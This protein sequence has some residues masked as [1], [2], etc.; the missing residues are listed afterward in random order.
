MYQEELYSNVHTLALFYLSNSAYFHLSPE[1]VFSTYILK[2][3]RQDSRCCALHLLTVSFY[4]S[5]W[6]M[7]NYCEAQKQYETAIILRRQLQEHKLTATYE[8]IERYSEVEL[9]FRVA[10]CLVE[11]QQFKEAAALL[12]PLPLKQRSAKINML[13]AKIQQGESDKHL[14][15]NYKE[16]LRKCPLA[17]ECIDGL[18]S[19]GVKGTEVNSLIINGEAF[20]I[21]SFARF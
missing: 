9:K 1:E 19:L 10:K 16:V 17:F 5:L 12:Q 13:L 2:G 18:L 21:L 7:K 6:E 4:F 20:W 3:N 15:A 8:I 14:I 11:N